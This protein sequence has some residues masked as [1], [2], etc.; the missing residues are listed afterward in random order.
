M[1]QHL[2]RWCKRCDQ[3]A[4]EVDLGGHDVDGRDGE[5]P[6]LADDVVIGR[7][8]EHLYALAGHIP[9]PTKSTTSAPLPSIKSSSTTL[10]PARAHLRERSL[11]IENPA[12][13]RAV[14]N[15]RRRYVT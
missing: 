7:P 6:A 8:A 10:P 1:A 15:V 4:D 13:S 11:P 12:K 9:S 3:I 2:S 5:V 14:R